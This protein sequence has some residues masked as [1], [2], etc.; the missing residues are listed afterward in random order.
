L[1]RCLNDHGRDV[2]EMMVAYLTIEPN[3]HPSSV[4]IAPDTLNMAPVGACLR[5]VLSATRFPKGATPQSVHF[6]LKA[7]AKG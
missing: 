1:T 7:A 3:G 4:S 6:T 2:T 5:N